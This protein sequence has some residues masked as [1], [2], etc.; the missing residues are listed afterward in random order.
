[1]KNSLLMIMSS[2]LPLAALKLFAQNNSSMAQPQP[3]QP[4]QRQPQ[5]D[6]SQGGAS[7]GQGLGTFTLPSGQIT[8]ND[9]PKIKITIQQMLEKLSESKKSA[10]KRSDN[11]TI[12][13]GILSFQDWLRQQ[14]CISQASSTYDLEAE[15]KYSDNIF[16]TSPGQLPI[17]IVFKMGGGTKQYRMLLFVS[18]VDFLRFGSL[19]ENRL[20]KVPVPQNWP[21]NYMPYFENR[22]EG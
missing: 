22:G 6:Q 4:Q 9:I 1:V 19:V 18:P 2:F 8:E 17:D 5:R 15:D 12:K 21:K 13:S 11:Q 20:E 3:G 16:I 10:G 7:P 14:G